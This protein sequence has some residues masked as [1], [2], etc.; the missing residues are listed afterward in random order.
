MKRNLKF[1]LI[2]TLLI[3]TFSLL[4]H[5]QDT[6]DELQIMEASPYFT[7]IPNETA[8]LMSDYDEQDLIDT[9]AEQLLEQKEWVDI[10]KFGLKENDLDYIKYSYYKAV[11]SD[12][13][14]YHMI[15]YFGRYRKSTKNIISGIEPIYTYRDPDKMLSVG[16][17]IQAE[18]DRI[19]SYISDDM[20]DIE[21]L[22]IILNCIA[23]ETEYDHGLNMRTLEDVFIYHKSVCEGYALAFFA[24]ADKAGIECGFTGGDSLDGKT[25]HV[26]NCVKIDGELYHVDATWCDP[27]PDL[28][29]RVTYKYFLKSD[30]MFESE[31]SPN[32][33]DHNEYYR[34]DGTSAATIG[35][36][37]TKYDNAFWND[38]KSSIVI[39]DGTWFY[40]DRSFNIIAYNPDTNTSKAVYTFTKPWPSAPGRSWS[41]SLSGI[42]YAYGKLYFNTY[43]SI[44]SMN[45]DGS[46]AKTF[47]TLSDYSDTSIYNCYRIKDDIFYG[48]GTRSFPNDG[49]QSTKNKLDYHIPVTSIKASIESLNLKDDDT[50]TFDVTVLPENAS[51]KG[52][53]CVSGNP[54][55]ATCSGTTVKATG[56]G[57]TY[58]KILSLDNESI[59]DEINVSVTISVKGIK[60]DTDSVT[61]T[62]NSTAVLNAQVLPKNATD[63]TV[64][65]E[66]SDESIV[67]VDNGAIKAVGVGEATVTATTK[68]GNFSASVLV[69]VTDTKTG[70]LNGD[71][72]ITSDDAILLLKSV[73]FPDKYQINYTSST[74][75]NNDGKVNSDDAVRLL[76]FVLF[77]DAFPIS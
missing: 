26:W 57:S 5:A 13:R 32:K 30:E 44:I 49:V 6:D 46:D 58:I 77:P 19:L 64:I 36:T 61:L 2:F 70:D 39:A 23:L 74:D 47:L 35:A 56:S 33:K 42:A 50:F 31:N 25:G 21:K 20:S 75:F 65:W 66:S 28:N 67:T 55:V 45:T 16:N 24:L 68:D 27:S 52:Y 12:K 15:A 59:T 37:S 3:L 48:T 51:N 41:V 10:S 76:L 38:L 4:I 8:S 7:Y 9:I 73:L 53:V 22:I 18:F 71:D 63:K 43:N 60:L 29:G 72:N 40:D 17:E 34:I 11:L 14:L 69:T 54:S 1:T 62:Q